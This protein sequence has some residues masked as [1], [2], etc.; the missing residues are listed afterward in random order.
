M[1]LLLLT[2]VCTFF[3]SILSNTAEAVTTNQWY[4]KASNFA[5]IR[6]RTSHISFFS[7]QTGV[8]TAKK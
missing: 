8:V 4:T 7:I 2:L 5:E 3:L 6:K 1:P